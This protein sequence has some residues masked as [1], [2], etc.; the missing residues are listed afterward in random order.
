MLDEHAPCLLSGLHNGRRAAA[1]GFDIEVGS[2][3]GASS[4][5]LEVLRGLVIG[6]SMLMP[7]A[8]TPTSGAGRWNL[9]SVNNF[10]APLDV[11]QAML[12]AVEPFSKRAIRCM[13]AR[14]LQFQRL[15][16]RVDAVEALTQLG[17]VRIRTRSHVR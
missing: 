15:E 9:S 7:P 6:Y 11:I 2:P 1:S 17:M 12:Y 13:Q 5:L 10:K 14:D 3:H 8:H 16:P 4:G